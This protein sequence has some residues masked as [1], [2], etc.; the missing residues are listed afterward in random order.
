MCR[1]REIQKNRLKF[2]NLILIQFTKMISRITR[3]IKNRLHYLMRSKQLYSGVQPGVT[4]KASAPEKAELSDFLGRFREIVSDPLNLLIRRHPLA[5][6][7]ENGFVYLH[8]GIKVPAYGSGAYYQ[9]FSD[10]LVINRGVHEPLEE[11]V[12]QQL[13]DVLPESPSMLELGAYWGHYSM[14]C[15]SVRPKAIQFLVEPDK[16]NIK[17]AKSNFKTN[18]CRG[19][20]IN[21]FVGKGHFGVDRFLAENKIDNLTILHSDIQGFELQMLE[22]AANSLRENRVDYVFVSTHSNKLHLECIGFLE[23]VGYRVEI[24]S[25]F[26]VEST[27]CDGFIF[28]SKMSLK[29]VFESTKPLGRVAIASCHPSELLASLNSFQ[30]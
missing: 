6:C 29:P 14:W 3:K 23:S 7:L 11:Y 15:Q 22:D 16:S 1:R 17:V 13:L 2:A 24:E 28:A 5:G 10:I 27:S 25:D 9:E 19:T 20:F 21:A 18:N 26:D 8:N 4:V 30:T 12:F